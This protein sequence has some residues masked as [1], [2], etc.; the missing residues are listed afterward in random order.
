MPDKLTA[1]D[2]G[3]AAADTVVRAELKLCAGL[4]GDVGAVT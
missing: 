1:A 2:T 4:I 3:D